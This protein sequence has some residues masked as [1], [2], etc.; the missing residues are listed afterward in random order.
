MTRRTG[1]F[2][3]HCGTNIAA[4]VDVKKVARELGKEDG[5]VVAADHLDVRH[6]VQE[7]Q[8]IGDLPGDDRDDPAGD[9]IQLF[10]FSVR[11]GSHG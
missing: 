8:R 3:C 11:R 6:D 10:P 2:V 9:G 1:V 4:T 5:V 7:D